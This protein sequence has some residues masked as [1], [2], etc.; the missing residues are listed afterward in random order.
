MVF[1]P[2]L[3]IASTIALTSFTPG[4][5]AAVIPMPM[6]HATQRP[7]MR[8]DTYVFPLVSISSGT[9]LTR[10]SDLRRMDKRAPGLVVSP[11]YDVQ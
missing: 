4:A 10:L 11:K 2:S 3:I 8:E 7:I 5:G 6:D 9:L 1:I